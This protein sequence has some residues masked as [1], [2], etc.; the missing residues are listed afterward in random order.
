[1]S[2]NIDVAFNEVISDAFGRYS[3]YIIQ[4]RAIPDARDGLKPGQRRILYSMYKS[5]NLSSKE[6]RKSAKTVGNVIGNYHPHGDSSIYE[7]MIRMSQPWKLRYPLIDM[8]GNNGSIDNDSAAAMRYTESKMTAISEMLLEDIDKETINWVL[9]FDDTLNEPSVL[10]AKFFNLLA[11]GA[12]GIASGYA[13]EIPP[14]NLSEL[15]NALIYKLENPQASFNELKKIIKGPDFPTGGIIIFPK[16]FEKIFEK[17]RGSVIIRSKTQIIEKNN[18]NHIVISEIPYGVYKSNLV[19]NI[20]QIMRKNLASNFIEI[21][22]ESDRNELKIVI[23]L[24]KE[25]DCQKILDYLFQKSLMQ[26][27]Y[28]Y[29]MVTIIDK[30]PILLGIDKL[31]DYYIDYQKQ[32]LIKKCKFMENKLEKRNEILQGFLKILN[33]LDEAIALIRKAKSK[34][35]AKVKLEAFFEINERQSEAIVLLRLYQLT[36]TDLLAIRSELN[37]NQEKLTSIWEILSSPQLI[38]KELKNNFQQI[39]DKFGDKRRTMISQNEKIIKNINEKDLIANEEII[40]TLSKD[41]YLKRS[42]IKAYNQAK[43]KT[44]KVLEKDLIILEAKTMLLNYLVIFLENGEFV[45]IPIFDIREEKWTNKGA[46]FSSFLNKPI[47]SKIINAFIIKDF[48]NYNFVIGTKDGLVKKINGKGLQISNWKRPYT[49]ISLNPQDKVINVE[50][51]HKEFILFINN[52]GLVNKFFSSDITT[53]GLKSKGIKGIN[54]AGSTYAVNMIVA[55]QEDHALFITNKNTAKRIWIHKIPIKNRTTQGTRINKII[56]SN[57][58][59]ITYF[60]IVSSSTILHLV[61]YEN[62]EEV[63]VKN[64]PILNVNDGNNAFIAKK[65]NIVDAFIRLKFSNLASLKL[66]NKTKN[67]DSEKKDDDDAL[68]KNSLFDIINEI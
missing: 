45:T 26:V 37:Q 2:K 43:I 19:I 62:I 47:S 25:S 12:S 65:F 60:T 67:K 50:N 23:E 51:E 30:K 34:A 46:H 49:F 31:L 7:A 13:T 4:D 39:I 27:Y 16:G 56:K 1:M 68:I 64:I 36:S 33:S 11:N 42:S 48:E 58:Q 41:G 10:P 14:H 38:I 55:K 32:I 18:C 53:S 5:N 28:N 52:L 22:D 6:Y 21:R 20:E 59:T 63:E 57:P 61:S 24:T 3:K 54:L 29:N 40:L 44:I 17:G 9:N 35:D 15:M 66:K 8:H